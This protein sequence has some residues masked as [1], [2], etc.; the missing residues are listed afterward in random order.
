MPSINLKKFNSVLRYR[1]QILWVITS[2]LVVYFIFFAVNNTTRPSYGFASYYTASNLLIEGED[3]ADFYD[4]DW[5]SSKVENYVHGVYEIY[6]VNMPTTALIF[7]PIANFDYKTA[8]LIWII[9]NLV[10][11]AVVVGLIIRRM[12]FG[13]IWL[14]LVLISFLSFQPLYVN[15]SNGQVYSFIFCLL[16]LAWFAYESGI[17][18]LLGNI[19]GV[20]FI[21]KTAGSFLIILF[22]FQK[23]WKSLLW[24]F[25]TVVFYFIASLPLLGLNSWSAYGNKLLSYTSSPTLSVTAYQSV[26]SFFHHL[27]VFDAQWNLEPL[28]N[29]PLIGKSLTIIFSLGILIVT[30]VSALKFKKSD[31]AFGSFI[32]AGLILNPATIDYHYMLILIPIIILIDWL[33]NNCSFS[34]WAIFLFSFLLIALSIP[35]TSAKVTSGLWAVLAY[36]KLYGALGLLGLVLRASYVSKSFEK[37]IKYSNK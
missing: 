21:L 3:V 12:K 19:I 14:P 22:A 17:D 36:P 6:L 13:E 9:F 30:I 8:R 7:L 26:H 24:V 18:T 15:I 4:D 2:I 28:I 33:K 34:M 29:L 5:F 11:L 10:L 16:V 37:R 27:F 35:Y 25:V 23:K 1:I 31:L 32:I 20:V